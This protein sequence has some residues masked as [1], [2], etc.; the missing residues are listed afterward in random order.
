MQKIIAIDIGSYSI[1]AIE[2]L[3]KIKSYE[4]S[5]V[6]EKKLPHLEEP[7]PTLISVSLKS[8]F[9]EQ[10]IQADRIITAMPGQYI[11]SRIM[12]FNFADPTKIEAAVYSEIEDIV[13]FNIEDMILDQQILGSRNG[14]TFTL[15]VLTKKEFVGTFLDNLKSIGIDPKLIDVDSLSFY[16]LSPFLDMQKGKV[17]GIVDIGHEKTS[18]CLVEDNVLRMFRSINLGGRFITEFIARDMQISYEEAESLKHEVSTILTEDF[19]IGQLSKNQKEVAERITLASKSIARELGRTLYAFKTWEKSPIEKIYLCG[20]SS[21]IQNFDNYMTMQLSV[22][23]VPMNLAKSTLQYHPDLASALPIMGQGISIGIR[24]VSGAKKHSQI[25]LRKGDF[26]YVQDYAAIL[27]TASLVAK[28][29]ALALFLLTASYG[30]K[31]FFYNREITSIQGIYLKELSSLSDSKKKIKTDG[32]PFAKIHKDAIS[33][34]KTRAEQKAKAFEDFV[35]GNANSGALASMQEISAAVPKDVKID[36]VDYDYS[37]KPDG[38]GSL[39][40]RVE[41][42]SFETLDKLKERLGSITVFSSVQQISSDTKP[43]TDLKIAVLETTYNAN[44]K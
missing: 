2:I 34:I 7:D 11:S 36:V 10:N 21:L 30:V 6:F 31:Y 12:A 9:D 41:A 43:G 44:R 13:P 22:P 40:L 29:I 5:N 27:N 4:V 32:V 16:N 39:K 24:S 20:G 25:N 8:L 15:V 37:T 17:Y 19:P 23:C 38:T 14:R 3:N 35:L 26:A 1:K 33:M 28:I 42:D 18:M